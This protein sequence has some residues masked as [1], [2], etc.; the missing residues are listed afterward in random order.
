VY[1]LRIL[2]TLAIGLDS[3]AAP[4][5]LPGKLL[6]VRALRNATVSAT[7]TRLRFTGMCRRLT[8]LISASA[9]ARR[10]GV[11]HVKQ[12]EVVEQ[13]K[14][15]ARDVSTKNRVSCSEPQVSDQL[16]GA[17]LAKFLETSL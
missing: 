13:F 10:A 1:A 8:Q 2:A 3:R 14:S 17:S 15:S 12:A 5:A 9:L 16:A 7:I 6:R 11:G 4:A